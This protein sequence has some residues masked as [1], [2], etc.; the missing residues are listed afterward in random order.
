MVIVAKHVALYSVDNVRE[1]TMRTVTLS[2]GKGKGKAIPLQVGQAL[3][4]PGE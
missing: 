2:Q 1:D 3:R 4:F